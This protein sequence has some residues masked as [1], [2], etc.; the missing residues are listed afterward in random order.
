MPTLTTPTTV[1]F[2]IQ[3]DQV[4][5][6]TNNFGAGR[7]TLSA[8]RGGD[9]VF[10]YTGDQL[11]NTPIFSSGSQGLVTITHLSGSLTYDV[12][13]SA[14]GLT[15][16]E[17]SATRASVLGD[18]I[19]SSLIGTQSTYLDIADNV[20]SRF[21][22]WQDRANAANLD[23]TPTQFFDPS[24]T[25]SAG[26][27]SFTNPFTT[28][29]QLTNWA[30][31][32]S[33]NLGGRCLGFKRGTITREPISLLNVYG[34]PSS[35]FVIAPYGSSQKLPQIVLGN[36]VTTWSA[37]TSSPSNGLI[38]R[39]VSSVNQEIYQNGARVPKVSIVLSESALITAMLAA[40]TGC[41][42]FASGFMYLY[43]AANEN[44]N[45]GQVEMT[46]GT[47]LGN[48]SAPA[49]LITPANL[50]ASRAGNI[51]TMGIVTRLTRS[52]A[53]VLNCVLGGGNQPMNVHQ[54]YCASGQTGVD[55][56]LTA[57]LGSCAAFS[58]YG[59]TDS[60][61][62][63]RSSVTNCFAFYALNNAFES[64]CE[65]NGLWENNESH[66]TSGNLLEWYGSNSNNVGRY[67]RQFGYS[68]ATLQNGYFGN[69]ALWLAGQWDTGGATLV[70]D[71][72][73]LKNVGNEFYMNFAK[74]SA[75]YG[76]RVDGGTGTVLHHNTLLYRRDGNMAGL[77]GSLLRMI[78]APSS[79]TINV[80]RNAM[81]MPIANGTEIASV[82]NTTLN[83]ST[84]ATIAGDYNAY[85]GEGSF[86]Q[87]SGVSSFNI[88]AWRAAMVAES[89][90]STFDANS[91]FTNLNDSGFTAPFQTSWGVNMATGEPLTVNKTG[92]TTATLRG[93]GGAGLGYI[94]DINGMPMPLTAPTIGCFA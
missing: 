15:I 56:S 73:G 14:F 64:T 92:N 11:R 78:S 43:P 40:G 71:S 62:L 20:K 18:G 36:T 87:R 38:Y 10:D 34:S 58:R 39:V 19:T 22:Q 61:R 51:T 57:E 32:L 84:G 2:S 33:G 75:L 93:Q 46:T 52:Y 60:T 42:G 86:R 27:G 81:I 76:M 6:L 13:S 35:P 48:A 82:V 30:A 59:S 54:M 5:T 9:V 90:T 63:T 80:S 1:T 79:T 23:F 7:V 89:P 91:Q 21:L 50:N 68:F 31:S 72:T 44:P 55:T 69:G 65:D 47:G 83:G 8:Q 45:L 12:T 29:T 17:I 41:C 24:A 25:N 53:N 85:L 37:I 16:P 49:L 70:L 28:A 4:L 26:T 3:I 94:R 74:N 66:Q 77:T 67:S 88:Q